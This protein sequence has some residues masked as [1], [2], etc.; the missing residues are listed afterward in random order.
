MSWTASNHLLEI[1]IFGQKI[2]VCRIGGGSF[3]WQH[4]LPLSNKPFSFLCWKTGR[5][6]K[7]FYLR[8]VLQN[9]A[10]LNMYEKIDVWWTETKVKIV[11]HHTCAHLNINASWTEMFILIWQAHILYKVKPEWLSRKGHLEFQTTQND[12]QCV[13]GC[14]DSHQL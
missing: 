5:K 7:T 12:W 11:L 1:E 8:V 10:L 3:P 13:I 9:V 14:S 2:E 4:L 6:S